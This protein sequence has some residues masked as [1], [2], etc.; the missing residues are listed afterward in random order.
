[1][2]GTYTTRKLKGGYALH[3]I[4]SSHIEGAILPKELLV[5]G[6]ES[7]FFFHVPVILFLLHTYDSHVYVKGALDEYN[8]YLFMSNSTEDFKL[9]RYRNFQLILPMHFHFMM[10][11]VNSVIYRVSHRLLYYAFIEVNFGK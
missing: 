2:V 5:S 11:F 7:S 4:L 10:N 8:I 6:A 9:N 3:T 1:M